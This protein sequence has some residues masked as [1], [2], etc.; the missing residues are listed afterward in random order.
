M[1]PSNMV[2]VLEK[3]LVAPPPNTVQEKS[4]PLTFF[5]L[6][7]LH[8]PLIHHIFF[9]NYSHSTSH[10]TSEVIPKLKD[11]LSLTL[12]HYFPLAGHLMVPCDSSKPKIYYTDGDSVSLAIM[13]SNQDFSY[14]TSNIARNCDEFYP[15]VPKLPPSVS[16]PSGTILAP[17]L[18]VQVTLFPSTG[19]SVGFTFQRVP[20]DGSSFHGFIRSWAEILKCGN[21]E[22]LIASETLPHY[23]RSLIN[24]PNALESI[25]WNQIRKKKFE[26]AQPLYAPANNV[27]ATFIMHQ[28]DVQRLKKMVSEKC[29]KLSHVT[30]FTVT[31]AYIWTCMI[32]SRKAS[33]EEIKENDLEHFMFGADCR[34]LMVPPVPPN[35]FGN[36]LVYCIITE[37]TTQLMQEEEGFFIASKL[38]GEAIRDKLHD[39][40]KDGFLNGAE[41]WVTEFEGLNPERLVGVAGSP[42]F[43]VYDMD[44]GWGKPEKSE[45]VSIDASGSISLNECRDFKGDLEVG[46]SFP[47][48]KMEA[49]ATIFANGLIAAKN[50]YF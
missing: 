23:D 41:K 47:K 31:C 13:E 34:S 39:N 29:P 14:L 11:S 21:D 32:K 20:A 15:L 46:L 4:V 36:C 3:C 42:K 48:I 8:C 30:T 35:Y 9:C 28:S 22:A 43:A 2:S 17:L 44:F 18:A 33:G 50:A 24:D 10:F 38:M 12:K 7:F 27:R 25:F 40:K 19:I 45:V 49:F 6:P 26:G 1:A 5:D 16:Q 37:K